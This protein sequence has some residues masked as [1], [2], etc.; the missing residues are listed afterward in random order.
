MFFYTSF[1]KGLIIFYSLGQEFCLFFCLTRFKRSSGQWWIRDGYRPDVSSSPSRKAGQVRG[2]HHRT[3]DCPD[4]LVCSSLWS[5][6]FSC[7]LEMNALEGTQHSACFSVP[8]VTVLSILDDSCWSTGYGVPISTQAQRCQ[9][10][11]KHVVDT[12]LCHRQIYTTKPKMWTL[13]GH[14][15]F[16]QNPWLLYTH[17]QRAKPHWLLKALNIHCYPS[18]SPVRES[19]FP[20]WRDGIHCANWWRW[21]WFPQNPRGDR[22][23]ALAAQSCLLTFTRVLWHGHPPPHFIC[24]LNTT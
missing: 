15:F 6:H 7:S 20:G 23:L 22:A 3:G 24:T 13:L 1:Q 21:V 9:A 18:F 8:Q 17:D 19:P 4:S 12:A 10:S 14:N 11:N 2:A 16:Q 5:F